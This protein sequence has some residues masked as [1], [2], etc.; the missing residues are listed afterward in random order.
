MPIINEKES[1]MNLLISIIIPAYNSEKLIKE[2]IESVLKQT[3]PY[4]ELIIVDDGSTD[5]TKQIIRSFKDKRIRYIYQKNSGLPAKARN[6]GVTFAEGEYIAFLDSDDLW[7]PDKL[8]KQIDVIK[9]DQYIGL[10]GTNA[11]L[12]YDRKKT[13]IHIFNSLKTGYFSNKTFFPENKIIQ[14]TTLI[15]KKAFDSVGGLKEDKNLKA[16]EDFDLWVR[17][18]R[19]YPCYFINECLAYYRILPSSI[20]G[21]K[22]NMLQRRVNYYYNYF[23]HYSFSEKIKQKV[24]HHYLFHL[25]LAEFLNGDLIWMAHIKQA[26]KIKFVL[27]SYFLYVISFLPGFILKRIHVLSLLTNIKRIIKSIYC[28]CKKRIVK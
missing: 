2:T 24:I 1:K 7:L 10:V 28:A 14:S 9:Q 12:L 21:S 26:I 16:I 3:Y 19:Q 13:A 6:K 25:S 11:F 8:K 20:S 27:K 17:L 5:K 23:I 4:F 18:Y 22:I 15:N